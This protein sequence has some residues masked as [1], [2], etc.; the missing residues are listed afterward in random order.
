VIQPNL[1]IIGEPKT[2]TTALFNYLAQHQ[3]ICASSEKE[4]HFFA[5]DLI[6]ESKSFHNGQHEALTSSKKNYLNY[7]EP[8]DERYLMEASASYAKSKVAAKNIEEYSPNAKIIYGVREPTSWLFSYYLQL[9]EV[10]WEKE[11]T[12]KEALD[13]EKPRKEGRKKYPNSVSIPSLLHYRD[14]VRFDKHIQRYLSQV[15]SE[16]IYVYIYEDFKKDN[17]KTLNEIFDFLD[18][19]EKKMV[20][21]HKNVSKR[22][23]YE[24]L[25]DVFVD[26]REIRKIAQTLLPKQARSLWGAFVDRLTLAEKKGINSQL[27]NKLKSDFGPVVNRLQEIL[28]END[29]K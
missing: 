18:L 21:Q 13:A 29:L 7:F 16:Q 20:T 23:K 9:R 5:K 10:S 1:F 15:G 2:G 4:P 6:E 11:R 3:N 22:V 19:T 27:K 14:A 12:L 24:T 25:R 17:Q 8:R 28:A 26:S